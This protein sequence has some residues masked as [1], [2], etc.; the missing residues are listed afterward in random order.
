MVASERAPGRAFC[1]VLVVAGCLAASCAERRPDI[2]LVS[3]DSVRADA[4]TFRDPAA[5]PRLTE[6]AREGTVFTQAVSGS[7]WTLPAH[8]QL[9]TGTPPVLHG[10]QHDD[11]AIDPATPTLPE[12]LRAE[13]YFTAGFWTGWYLAG[14]YG[15]G[16]GF[17]LYENSMTQGD[18]IERELARAHADEELDSARRVLG[19]RQKLSHQDVTSHRVVERV[20]RALERVGK[21]PMFLFLHLFDPHY[22]YIPPAPWDTRFDPDYTGDVDGRDFYDNER[23]FDID[24]HPRRRIGKRD[25]DHIVALYR[26]EIAWTD[27]AVGRVLDLLDE[28]GRLD[29]AIVVVTSDHG[30][31]F[32]EHGGR[33]HRHFLWEELLRVP[34]LVRLPERLRPPGLPSSVT[35]QVD[36]SDIAPTLLDLLAHDVPAGVEGR[37]LLPA[38]RGSTLESRP[39]ISTL[40][41]AAGQEGAPRLLDAIR[42]EDYKLIRHLAVLPTGGLR[43]RE[44]AY[45]DLGSDPRELQ[46]RSDPLDPDVAAAVRA[47]DDELRRLRA[48]W[49]TFERSPDE[50]RSTRVREIFEDELSA[51]G[52]TD[53]GSSPGFSNPWGLGPHPPPVT[54]RD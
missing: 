19:A 3:L 17:D 1:R 20:S 11:L 31:E 36:L 30:D 16:R 22:D 26:G 38:L 18:M 52:Y 27:D 53:A 32:F 2:I 4:L 51:L 12:L 29:D 13:G 34:L 25:L 45:F 21:E 44:L 15:F 24:A 42:T 9:F 54:S 39:S 7:S 23:I 10:V 35:S 33:G 50:E 37:S 40:S 8:A 48:R 47:L 28:A 14:E 6:L 5:A 46:P 43:A 41:I 49:E